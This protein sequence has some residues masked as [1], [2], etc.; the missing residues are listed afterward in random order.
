MVIYQEHSWLEHPPFWWYLSGKVDIFHSD[1]LVHCHHFRKTNGK[2]ASENSSG[3]KRIWRRARPI[4][5]S[6]TCC[7][8]AVTPFI[9]HMLHGT[10]ICIPTLDLHILLKEHGVSIY[11]HD[12]EA[13]KCSSPME[14]MGL[15]LLFGLPECQILSTPGHPSKPKRASPNATPR[16]NK[17]VI[18]D[19]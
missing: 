9:S 7:L 10:G 1:M 5:M 18:R 11:L 12:K 19:Y 16:R 13:S 2:F 17:A 3:W 14:H 4:F 15:V 8:G 6:K